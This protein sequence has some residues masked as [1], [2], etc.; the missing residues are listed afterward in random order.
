[1]SNRTPNLIGLRTEMEKHGFA[2]NVS[3]SYVLSS[4]AA[5][6]WARVQ[7]IDFSKLKFSDEDHVVVAHGPKGSLAKLARVTSDRKFANYLGKFISVALI[8]GEVFTKAEFVRSLVQNPTLHAVHVS[9]AT[10]YFGILH[11]DQAAKY[12]SLIY[13]VPNGFLTLD[14][15][16]NPPAQ[17]SH[18][19]TRIVA[20]DPPKG[21]AAK[22]DLL[23]LFP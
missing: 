22:A 21:M 15:E 13:P 19:K 10:D 17:A 3:G 20:I 8:N 14:L 2:L 12:K 23:K 9:S 11:G 4:F 1:M 7:Q 5:D 18:M 16:E 6:E